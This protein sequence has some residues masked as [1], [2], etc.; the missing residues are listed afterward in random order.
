MLDAVHVAARA[1]TYLRSR[2]LE[3]AGEVASGVNAIAWHK[4]IVDEAF[5][6]ELGPDESDM[7][8]AV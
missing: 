6:G 2:F 7:E 8:D 3:D 4:W 1:P 5:S